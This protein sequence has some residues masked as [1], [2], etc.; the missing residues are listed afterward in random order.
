MKAFPAFSRALVAVAALVVGVR[1]AVFCGIVA[2]SGL[3]PAAVV[4]GHDGEEYI[5]FALGI[6]QAAPSA[7][8]ADSRR[9]D[10]GWPLFLAGLAWAGPIWLVSLVCGMALAAL[11]S[12]FTA[13]ICRN[14]MGASD[15]DA[16]MVALAAGVAYPS[17]VYFS[18]FAL[19]EPFFGALLAASF[20]AWCGQK[21][22]LAYLLVGFAALVRAPGILMAA[23]FLTDDLFRRR[24]LRVFVPLALA[25]LPQAAWLIVSRAVWGVTQIG[26]HHPQ[27]GLPFAGFQGLAQVGVARAAYVVLAVAVAVVL[28]ALAGREAFR[29]PQDSPLFVA[30]VFCVAYLGFHLCLRRLTY[31]GGQVFTFSYQDRYLVGMLPFVLLPFGRAVRPW[32]VALLCAASVAMSL[33]WGANYFQALREPARVN[34]QLAVH[35]TA[36]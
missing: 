19:T 7:I 2:F 22:G 8:S 6:A 9:H 25:I 17:A 28:S 15:R 32:L 3:S 16:L 1:L 13:F 33:Y 10:P 34:A 36:R 4:A 14:G 20:L 18:A 31:L 29:R 5:E 27:F 30:A 12:V 23:A 24:P 35:S 26:I 11:S 21:R